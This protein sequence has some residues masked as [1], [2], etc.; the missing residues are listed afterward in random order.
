ML[1]CGDT[2]R[3]HSTRFRVI[4]LGQPRPSSVSPAGVDFFGGFWSLKKKV[5]RHA[6]ESVPGPPSQDLARKAHHG[7]FLSAHASAA[8]ILRFSQDF[9]AAEMP[10]DSSTGRG[11]GGCHDLS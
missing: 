4:S 1:G 3:C 6:D 11:P 10:R 5:A 2:G 8:R 7:R 9:L